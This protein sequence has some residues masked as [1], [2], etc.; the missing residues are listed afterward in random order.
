MAEEGGVPVGVD[1]F[2]MLEHVAVVYPEDTV[3]HLQRLRRLILQ[4]LAQCC[5]P[6]LRV[7][8]GVAALPADS[9]PRVLELE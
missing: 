1:P 5:G 2:V 7:V 8:C 3:V 4:L 9:G 6:P